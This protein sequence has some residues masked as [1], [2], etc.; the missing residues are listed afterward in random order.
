MKPQRRYCVAC[1]AGRLP[2]LHLV[3]APGESLTDYLR[4][5]CAYLGGPLAAHNMTVVEVEVR[6]VP[7]K[8]RRK[9]KRGAE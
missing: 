6:V 4:R 7:P 8:K 5:M 2:W 9:A 3:S 1:T